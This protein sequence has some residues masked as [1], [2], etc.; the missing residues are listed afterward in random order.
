MGGS[1]P[2]CPESLP[3]LL[4]APL[5]C[6]SLSGPPGPAAQ[7][8]PAQPCVTQP[9]WFPGRMI[10]EP[11]SPPEASGSSLAGLCLRGASGPPGFRPLGWTDPVTPRPSGAISTA[12]L[13]KHSLGWGQEHGT[14]TPLCPWGLRDATTAL[15]ALICSVQWGTWMV[16]SR[17]QSTGTGHPIWGFP[18]HWLGAMAE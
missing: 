14:Q 2:L 8:S 15:W 10:Q 11:G 5:Q 12:S 7:P 9:G 16:G 3:S 18:E 1:A 13:Q 6:G 4:G 17:A